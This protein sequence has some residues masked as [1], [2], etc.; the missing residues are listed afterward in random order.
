MEMQ[1]KFIK[2]GVMMDL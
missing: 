1:K 2:N